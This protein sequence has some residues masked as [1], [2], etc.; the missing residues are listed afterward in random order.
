MTIKF[1]K[2]VDEILGDKEYRYFGNGYKNVHYDI[3]NLSLE[4]EKI[5]AF[6]TIHYPLAWSKKDTPKEL[7]PHL[8]TID[9]AYIGLQLSEVFLITLLDLKNILR[10]QMFIKTLHLKAKNGVLEDLS[11]VS[12]E[13]SY[14]V[15]TGEPYDKHQFSGQIG[16]IAFYSEIELPPCPVRPLVKK[17]YEE[18]DEIL[19]DSQDRY[20]GRL[21]EHTKHYIKNIETDCDKF[22][23]QADIHVENQVFN[24]D[25]HYGIDTFHLSNFQPSVIDCIVAIAQLSQ[26][27][28][29]EMDDLD[30]KNSQTLW[31]RN[32]KIDRKRVT[33]SE[34]HPSSIQ[35]E[36]SKMIKMRQE[37]WRMVDLEGKFFNYQFR[38]SLAH[39]LPKE[40]N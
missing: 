2:D 4:P 17:C 40:V 39:I 25:K 19:G 27:L 3:L 38:Y 33:E 20:F 26:V 8:S 15:V 5:T 9:A 28:I 6:T 12:C 23:S 10:N 13:I 24:I 31:M 32:V 35:V 18:V 30:R 7:V 34:Y 37:K 14:S 29:Y 22:T 1:C 16:N 36:K 21:Y 11:K